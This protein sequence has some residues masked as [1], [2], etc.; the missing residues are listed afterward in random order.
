MTD[1][2]TEDTPQQSHLEAGSIL[3]LA[4]AAAVATS[5]SYTVQPEL[6]LIAAD[7]EAS[8]ASTSAAAGLPIVGYMLGL[9]L[10]V[11]LVDRAPANALIPAQLA[12]LGGALVLTSAATS[13]EVF[14]AGLFLSGICASTGAQMST[15]AA[16]HSPPH[17][18][19]QAL[20]A[21]TAGISAGI[22]VGRMVGGGLTDAVGWRAMLLI[23]AST[24]LLCAVLGRALLPRR[25]AR[26]PGSWLSGLLSAPHLLRTH[27]DL[28]RSAAA[29]A[30]WFFAFSLIWVGVSLALALPPHGLSP[31]AV[32]LYSLAGLAGMA[33]TPLAGR[34]A[35][36]F[37]SRPIIVAGLLVALV[38]AMTMWRALGHAPLLL[39]ALAL[40]D[41]GLFAAQVANQRRVL[42]MDPL[43]P[44]QLNSTY[45]VIYFI[46][47][48]LGAAAGGPMVSTLG[49]PAAVGAA[50][51]AIIAAPAL[52]IPR[53][54]PARA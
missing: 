10:L 35:D 52:Y 44:A 24:S 50:A 18:R 33:A 30:L 19:G 46:G 9:A 49:W 51:L 53:P 5:T 15:L 1:P 40:F 8:V 47:G 20:G 38:C 28:L 21:V 23:V 13:V 12:A 34:L 2:R 4:L 45:M 32:G 11:P 7:L 17:R 37:G 25:G 42:N 54:D 27:P 43:R 22:L 39:L 26:A 48:S 31:T 16:K 29:G 14:G 6:G 41:A 3:F 36:R